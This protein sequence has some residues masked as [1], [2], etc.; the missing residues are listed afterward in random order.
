MILLTVALA[1]VATVVSV[2][3]AGLAI[4]AP[5]IDILHV[6]GGAG[7]LCR[8]AVSNG[9]RSISRCAARWPDFV[10]ALVGLIGLGWL[11]DDAAGALLPQL[12]LAVTGWAV[13]AAVPLAVVALAIATARVTVLRALSRL[14]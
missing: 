12:S 5:V 2:T 7:R 13:L 10:L 9:M 1:A 6:M 8:A 3:R 11:V 14:P 4:H